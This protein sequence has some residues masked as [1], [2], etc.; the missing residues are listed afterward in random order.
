MNRVRQTVSEY[1]RQFW[2]LFAGMLISA[3]GSSMVWPFL[4]IYLRQRFAV[5]LTT[6]ALLLSLYSG[7]SLVTTFAAG[8]ATDR[9]GRKG[10]MVL[11]LA[12]SSTVYAAMSLAGTLPL[13]A[14]LMAANGASGPL[15]RVGANAMV[16]DLVGPDRRPDAYALLRMSTNVGVALG[17][18]I[19]GFIASVSYAWTFSIAAVALA[20]F[21]LL[22]LL[23]A[24]ETLTMARPEGT[25]VQPASGGGYGVLVRDRPFLALCGLSTLA[26]IP[27][28]L[29]MV[30]LPVYA[31][32][33]F[34]VVE[35]QYGFIMAT[36]AGMVVVFQYAVTRV[37]KRYPPLIMLSLGALV[38]ALGVGS[39]ALGQGFAAFLLSMVIFTVGEMIL[40]PTGTTWTAD[41]APADMR[42]RYMS[43]YG[44]TW[45]LGIGIGPVIGGYLNDNVAPVAIWYGGL[46]IGLIPA[47][48]YVLLAWWLREPVRR[49]V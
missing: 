33:Q 11:S 12:A 3:T 7:A 27:A 38:Y 4:T 13:W 21:A 43:I 19:G 48:G 32:E 14:V 28:S 35:S 42:G 41:R 10:V 25:R 30:L 45:G 39:V 2:L 5:P 26:V 6:V 20:G 1:P 40:V 47:L 23:F 8:P 31:K 34:G 29:L 9:Y 36:N 44:M 17:P 16:A 18:S 15:Y 22:I 24:V 49:A 37:T 46:V